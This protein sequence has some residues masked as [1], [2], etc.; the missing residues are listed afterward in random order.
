MVF[1][2]PSIGESSWGQKILDSINFLKSEQDGRLSDASLTASYVQVTEA[3]L[4]PKRYGATVDGT[5][6]PLS[7][8]Y[9]TLAAA[10]AVYPH[11]TSLSETL[12]WAATQ[13]ALNAL[14]T[15][16]AIGGEVHI[17]DGYRVNRPLKVPNGGILTGEGETRTTLYATADFVGS[18][19]IMP[20]TVGQNFL[21]VEKMALAGAGVCPVGVLFDQQFVGSGVKRLIASN[22]ADQGILVRGLSPISAGGVPGPVVIEDVWTYNN[23]KQ[24]VLVDGS[25]INVWMERVTSENNG[26]TNA[27][28]HIRQPLVNAPSPSRGHHIKG[29][30]V[31]FGTNTAGILLENAFGVTIEDVGWDG[32][33]VAGQALLRIVGT[34]DA[35]GTDQYKPSGITAR[36]LVCGGMSVCVDDQSRG[37]QLAGPMVSEYATHQ[38]VYHRG[39]QL[40]AGGPS[41]LSGT[42]APAVGLGKNGDLYVRSDG[43]AGTVIYQKRAGAWVA[44]A[45]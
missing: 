3:P 5:A 29:A 26:A 19:L 13:K 28:I 9:A 40:S 11:A 10:Q 24:G 41:M 18:A 14:P 31:E 27:Q 23:G 16:G 17:R 25:N 22:F 39:V 1:G 38:P 43:G 44:T 15:T 34:D 37:V 2:L 36:N 20:Q 12:D 30:H 33:A 42:G 6:H 4:N 45:A 35:T 8:K 32:T 21:W 7:E